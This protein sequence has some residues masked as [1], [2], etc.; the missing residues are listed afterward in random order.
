VIPASLTFGGGETAGSI[1]ESL[2]SLPRRLPFAVIVDVDNTVTTYDP[3]VRN[4]YEHEKAYDDPPN[5]D[6]CRLV[7]TIGGT[8]TPLIFCSGRFEMHRD[9]T[10]RWLKRYDLRPTSL[11][12]RADGDYRTDDVIKSEIYEREIVGRWRVWLVIDDRDRVV[13]MWRALGL[14]CLQVREGAF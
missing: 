7:R 4:I 10:E 3:A 12:M 1:A 6:V 11:F 2:T 5:E 14:T 8:G 13:K 9:V